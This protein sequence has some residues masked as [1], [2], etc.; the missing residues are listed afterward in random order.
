MINP[1]VLKEIERINNL[2]D[3]QARGQ[4]KGYG[5]KVCLFL[6]QF[7]KIEDIEYK[8]NYNFM[9]NEL[10]NKYKSSHKDLKVFNAIIEIKNRKGNIFYYNMNFEERNEEEVLNRIKEYPFYNY[11]S[12]SYSIIKNPIFNKI[13]LKGGLKE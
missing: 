2:N 13:E 11:N 1:E 8:K 9:F 4:L 6:K 3:F 10:E 12:K 7:Y 5:F